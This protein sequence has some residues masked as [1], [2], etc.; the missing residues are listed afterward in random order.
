MGKLYRAAV[1]RRPHGSAAPAGLKI[2]ILHTFVMLPVPPIE[3]ASTEASESKA[4]IDQESRAS[5]LTPLPR[6]T[7][8]PS[9]PICN[10]GSLDAAFFLKK[11]LMVA[12]I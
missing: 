5:H 7:K 10:M 9:H 4:R 1:D 8:N 6:V 2:R 12:T 3:V 11:S